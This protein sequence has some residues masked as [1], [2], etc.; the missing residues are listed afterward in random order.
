M[1]LLGHE[2][3]AEAAFTDLLDQLVGTDLGAGAPVARALKEV[4]NFFGRGLEKAAIVVV[5]AYQGFHSGLQ[6]AVVAAGLLDAQ[7]ACFRRFQA[8]GQIEDSGFLMLWHDHENPQGRK[9][10]RTFPLHSAKKASR[11]RGK[12]RNS[13]I[14][15]GKSVEFE[16]RLRR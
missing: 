14:Q 16:P 4:L 1:L 11:F 7:A 12:N 6:S 3:H 5:H 9:S 8:A 13:F 2:N 15:R 10:E